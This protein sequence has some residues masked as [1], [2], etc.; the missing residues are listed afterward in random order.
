MTGRPR[1]ADADDA[2]VDATLALLSEE[3]FDR[4]AMDAVAARAGV[5]KATIY[6][7]WPSKEALVIDAVAR[8]TDPFPEV[9]TG[10][11]RDRLVSLLAGILGMSRT[12]AGR[13][14]P[15][16]VGATATNPPL[17]EH[18]RAQILEPRRN[19]MRQMVRMAVAKGELRRGVDVDDAIDLLIGALLY[20]I[21]FAGPD[22]VADDVPGRLVD[23]ALRGLAP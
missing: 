1:N 14:L 8:R 4:L 10:T 13:L 21:V 20:R 5:A 7:R 17:A 11:I 3:G 2:I 12:G 22:G 18:Y 15:C 9:A 23:A 6:R 16:M 19:R